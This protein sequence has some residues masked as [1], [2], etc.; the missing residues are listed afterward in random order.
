MGEVR[1]KFFGCLELLRLP[2]LGLPL[3]ALPLLT[4]PLLALPL[5]ASCTQPTGADPAPSGT[6]VTSQPS[7]RPSLSNPPSRTT[8]SR[9]ATTSGTAAA[10][11][12]DLL[13][14]VIEDECL[15]TPAQFGT[16]IGG[17]VTVAENTELADAAG[18]RSC[19]YSGA[20]AQPF[21]RIDVYAPAAA[22]AGELVT[23]IAT[24]GA[25]SL[26]GI[27]EGCVVV[28]GQQGSFELVVA[29]G[30][31]LVVLTLPPGTASTPPADAAW[32][33]AATAMLSHLPT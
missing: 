7:V 31:L 19:F 16:L 22:S 24:N 1:L 29:S 27:G 3:P 17:T 12:T 25:K 4:L 2:L 11:P 8:T 23:R 18:R 14:N 32:S 15:L 28:S 6:S 5:L 9:P 26:A 33:A 10:L 21:G 13:P 30:A 20:Q